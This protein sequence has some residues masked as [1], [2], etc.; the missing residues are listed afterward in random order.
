[1][2]WCFLVLFAAFSC[3]LLL[4]AAVFWD[5]LLL[6]LFAT[7][8]APKWCQNAPQ[9][10][11]NTS[12]IDPKSTQNCPLE[13]PGPPRWNQNPISSFWDRFWTPI[14]S[15]LGPQNRPKIDTLRE[16]CSKKRAFKP[17]FAWRGASPHFLYLFLVI[18]GQ[19]TMK[20]S[21]RCCASCWYFPPLKNHVFYR[22]PCLWTVFLQICWNIGNLGKKRKKTWKNEVLILL[23]KSSQKASPRHPKSTPN[24]PF[25]E[26][27]SLKIAKI[28]GKTEFSMHRF[29]ER[30]KE[31]KKS[32]KRAPS[33]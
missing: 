3:C 20:N 32:Q 1:M 17:M 23:A 16:K 31:A 22:L 6:A 13:H 11:Q 7:S 29:F 9:R 21:S 5:V 25:W 26:R 27:K 19:K 18:F 10:P 33:G 12:K 2:I 4:F 30:K 15:P 28:V 14:W 24:R 8:I